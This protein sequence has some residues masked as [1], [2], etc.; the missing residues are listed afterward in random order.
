MDIH[1]VII[2]CA[3]LM[4]LYGCISSVFETHFL[5]GPMI[6][7]L[8]GIGLSY[9][10]DDYLGLA[11]H[12]E[13]IRFIAE[14][15]L[16]I[17]LFIDASEIKHKNLKHSDGHVAIR[18]LAI[19]LPLTALTGVIVGSW[20]FD[21]LSLAV[22]T[23]IALMLTPT[24]AALGQSLIK[25]EKLKT[26]VKQNIN[27][28]SGLNDGVVLPPIIICIAAISGEIGNSSETT[29]A[30]FV[31]TQL[32]LG[33]LVGGCIGWFGGKLI[34]HAV[35][36]NWM[37]PLYQSICAL[38]LPLL[39]YSCAEIV[40]G[41]G[42]IAAF[43]CGYLFGVRDRGVR[44]KMQQFGEAEGQQLTLFV[45]LLFGFV[46]VPIA[47]EFWDGKAVIYAILSL[48]LV[49][50]IPVFISL[51]ASRA[52]WQ[53]Q[54]IYAWFGPRGIASIL[55]LLMFISMVGFEGYQYPVSV[56]ILTVLMSIFLHGLTALPI[57]Q[58]YKKSITRH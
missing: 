44:V 17:V 22:I 53:E 57:A 35:H 46:M 7:S 38:A 55:Y 39:A 9:C 56:I 1:L 15:T 4:L 33:P 26:H 58:W 10:V 43:V 48:T 20:V 31:L 42:F 40:H 11:I 19:G 12:T 5:T 50:M 49:R 51:V 36:R 28:E 2:V 24:D 52:P 13:V 25:S 18:L 23:L 30:M 32:I 34:E 29:W 21:S 6:F 27:V 14:I 3:T 45:F 41:N 54:L 16:I 37:A 47:S 8:S